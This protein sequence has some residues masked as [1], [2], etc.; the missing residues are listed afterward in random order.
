[1]HVN[2]VYFT[3]TSAQDMDS[4]STAKTAANVL[5]DHLSSSLEKDPKQF[6]PW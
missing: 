5:E 4:L 2:L 1:M 6:I 3:Q